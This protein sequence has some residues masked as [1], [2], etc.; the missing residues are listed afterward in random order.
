M[1]IDQCVPVLLLHDAIGNHAREIQRALRRAGIASDLYVEILGT[2]LEGAAIP[3]DAEM[4]L[5]PGQ[6]VIYHASTDS[7]MA[8]W[9][10]GQAGK[11]VRVWS[12]YHNITPPQ[13]FA[14]WLPEAMEGMLSAREQ[15]Q[16][17]AAVTELAVAPSRFNESELIALGYPRTAVVPLLVDLT[18]FTGGV[19]STRN[20]AVARESAPLSESAHGSGVRWLFVGR[21]APNK[22]QHDVLAAFAVFRRLYEPGATLTLIGGQTAPSY[23]LAVR[24]MATDLG[25]GGAVEFRSGLDQEELIEEFSTA[26]VFVC[27]SEHEGYC[28]PLLEAMGAG[29]PIV[30]LAAGAVAET[31]GHAGVLLRTKDPVEVAWTVADVLRRDG[32]RAQLVADGAQRAAELSLERTS[33]QMVQLLTSS[34]R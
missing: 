29:V 4:S 32:R 26:D 21:F 19:A 3:F 10:I 28:V 1:R 30:A 14:K 23:A 24:E 31:V 12:Y 17:L 16:D 15:L 6:A 7:A 22:C 25:L 8:P 33:Q 27:L 18:A 13:Y 34:L 5:L 20:S 9:L 11:G 2:G